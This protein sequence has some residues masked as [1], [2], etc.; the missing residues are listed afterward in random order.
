MQL[1]VRGGVAVSGTSEVFDTVQS[2][3]KIFNLL[4]NTAYRLTGNH[5]LTA[6]LIDISMSAWNRQGNR[7]H[8]RFFNVFVREQSME[9][10][11]WAGNMLKNLCTAFIKK[12]AVP[13]CGLEQEAIPLKNYQLSRSRARIQEALL[14]LPPM[15][16]LLVVLRD[17]LGL[18]YADIAELTG[19]RKSDVT[20]LLSAGR[21][22]LR[23]QEICPNQLD[24]TN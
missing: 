9:R 24:M 19:L 8:Y 12:T 21:W 14:Q 13:V 22:S 15:E 1:T 2:H 5:Q 20:G 23:F 10:N 7:V 3:D 4:Y 16:R 18:T 17:I 11:M 6:E